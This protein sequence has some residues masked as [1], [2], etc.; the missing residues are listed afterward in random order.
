[1]E[2]VL[3]RLDSLL[4]GKPL[5]EFEEMWDRFFPFFGR[6]WPAPYFEPEGWFTTWTPSVDI[7]ES[8]DEYL[9]RG[10]AARNEERGS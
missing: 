4:Y 9:L 7:E 2:S 10:G 8:D 1:V 6:R 3:V 5:R